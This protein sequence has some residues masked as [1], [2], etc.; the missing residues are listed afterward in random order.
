MRLNYDKLIEL[1]NSFGLSLTIENGNAKFTDI[2]TDMP[3]ESYVYLVHNGKENASDIKTLFNSYPFYVENENKRFKIC[4]LGSDND[5]KFFEITKTVRKEPHVYEE[6]KLVSENGTN[7][8]YSFEKVLY[9]RPVLKDG[10]ESYGGIT[11]SYI[12]FY[13]EEITDNKYGKIITMS[14]VTG[15]NR[16]K[17]EMFFYKNLETDEI[18]YVVDEDVVIKTMSDEEAIQIIEQSQLFKETM[19]ILCPTLADKYSE[20]KAAYSSVK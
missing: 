1:L 16:K 14:P 8:S 19:N 12:K 6:S 20:V 9:E 4:V 13:A 17:N 5:A 18:T 3:M 2:E 7:A 11:L 10:Y 15:S